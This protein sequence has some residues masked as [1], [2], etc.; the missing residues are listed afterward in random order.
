MGAAGAFLRI[1]LFGCGLGA[2]GACDPA[3]KCWYG[4]DI[5]AL[6]AWAVQNFCP[7]CERGGC[8]DCAPRDANLNCTEHPLCAERRT[9]ILLS[10]HPT[11]CG[12][13]FER[14]WGAA[15]RLCAT[16]HGRCC[17][18][19]ARPTPRRCTATFTQGDSFIASVYTA[20]AALVSALALLADE[21][22]TVP[23]R[24]AYKFSF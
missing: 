12:D 15:H 2:A 19:C 9:D 20:A 3:L 4:D 21:A 1:F 23:V 18:D 8:D 6:Q 14:V 16:S 22:T 17:P 13:E 10:Q 7:S 5:A 24:S 11:G